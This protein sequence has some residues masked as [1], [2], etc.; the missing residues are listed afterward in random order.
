MK[1][2]RFEIIKNRRK[3]VVEKISDDKRKDR[4]LIRREVLKLSQR[5]DNNLSSKEKQEIIDRM[6]SRHMEVHHIGEKGNNTCVDSLHSQVANTGEILNILRK[7]G[8]FGDI[9]KSII[10]DLESRI[11]TKIM[12]QFPQKRVSEIVEEILQEGEF[13]NDKLSR[14]ILKIK[15]L[16]EDYTGELAVNSAI[17][18]ESSYFIARFSRRYLDANRPLNA[19]KIKKYLRVEFGQGQH[20]AQYYLLQRIFRETLGQEKEGEVEKPFLHI[21]LHGKSDKPDDVGDVMIANGLKKGMMP[22]DPQIARWFEKRLNEKM[23][24]NNDGDYFSAGVSRE[25]QRFCGNVIHCERRF[26]ND[27]LK[28]LGKNYQFIQVEISPKL[29]AQHFE[30]LSEILAEILKEFNEQFRDKGQLETFLK[31]NKSKEDDIRLEGKLYSKIGFDENILSGKILMGAS[32][33]MALDVNIG[34]KVLVDGEEFIVDKM[35]KNKI[36]FRQPF[37]GGNNMDMVNKKVVI[38]KK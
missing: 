3:D 4:G 24:K 7:R 35:T 22:C 29:R 25:G 15:K 13:K 34:D 9:D 30:K 32:H 31:S 16:Y 12:R 11:N 6:I 36:S 21:S 28:P 26:G 8:D 23:K 17:K 10:I 33:R 20:L 2:G 19:R 5:E 1:E 18:S 37:I 27:F 14:V 38:K